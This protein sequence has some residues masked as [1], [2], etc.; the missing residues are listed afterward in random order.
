MPPYG[1]EGGSFPVADR[2]VWQGLEQ[3][4]LVQS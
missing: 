4:F 2:A 3:S 1:I